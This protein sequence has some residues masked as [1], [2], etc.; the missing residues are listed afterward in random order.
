MTFLLFLLFALIGLGPTVFIRR[1]TLR[2][3]RSWLL[4]PSIGFVLIAIALT[5]VVDCQQPIERFATWL[6]LLAILLS[7]ALIFCNFLHPPRTTGVPPVRSST[8]ES[9]W[10]WGLSSLIIG[11]LIIAAPIQLGGRWFNHFR[12]NA[13]G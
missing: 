2:D 3:P 10:T 1:T 13:W 7:L 11:A 6:A 5:L 8:D 9:D 4:S 12:G